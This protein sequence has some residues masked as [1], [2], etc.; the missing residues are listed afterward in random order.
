LGRLKDQ[1]IKPSY[2]K[3]DI[4]PFIR[5]VVE[6]FQPMA[7]EKDIKLVFYPEENK[8]LMD[9]DPQILES[10]L[11]NVINNA[12][13][14][15]HSNG[16]VIIHL[17]S[18]DDYL[19]CIVKDNGPGIDAIHLEHL[20]DRFYQIPG[21]AASLGSGIGLAIVKEYLELLKG[22]VSVSSTK[23]V[24]TEFTIKLPRKA[25]VSQLSILN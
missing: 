11:F 1:K 19:Q 7:A 22:H 8:I 9:Y 4:I 10:I 12:I 18:T 16:N 3:G 5:N 24:G 6:E 23:N 21:H 2:R 25:S 15:G 14:F 13:K 20:F 17:R